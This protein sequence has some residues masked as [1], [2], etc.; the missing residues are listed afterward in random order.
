MRRNKSRLADS[1][2]W[3]KKPSNWATIAICAILIPILLIN[4]SVMIQ[5]KTDEDKVPTIFGYKPFIVLSDSMETKIKRGD[6]IIIKDLDQNEVEKLSERDIIAFRDD[7]NTVTTHRIVEVVD[8]NDE[9]YFVTKGD[10]NDSQDQSLVEYKDVEGIYKFRIPGVGNMFS[11]LAEPTTIIIIVLGITVIFGVAFYMSAKK[12]R[13]R[14]HE[15]F[16]AYKKQ[17]ELAKEERKKTSSRVNTNKNSSKS[18]LSNKKTSN[19]NKDVNN[20]KSSSKKT[21][22]TKTSAKKSNEEKT[23][24]NK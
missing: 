11:S 17:K 22:S 9:R 3:Y 23:P 8:E 20:K 16:L 18:S 15:E 24:K 14:E 7:E 21:S 19:N 2:K 13:E 5:A 12:E 1:D 4:I 10:N 6:L